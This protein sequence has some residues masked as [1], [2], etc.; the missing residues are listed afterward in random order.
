MRAR[1]V[2]F[3]VKG[4]NWC[5]SRSIDPSATATASHSPSTLKELW[6]NISISDKPINVKA[7]LLVDFVADKV[8]FWCLWPRFLCLRSLSESGRTWRWPFSQGE[9]EWSRSRSKQARAHSNNFLLLTGH[10]DN[11]TSVVAVASRLHCKRSSMSIRNRVQK[12]LGKTLVLEICGLRFNCS[13][14]DLLCSEL[15]IPTT[16]RKMEHL[17]DLCL[18][19]VLGSAYS[20]FYDLVVKGTGGECF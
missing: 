2:V 19:C 13:W 9:L 17:E 18:W 3:P 8:C 10:D 12:L 1:L 5:F 20:F 6:K 14:I 7:E 11:Q 4:R 16:I 15:I